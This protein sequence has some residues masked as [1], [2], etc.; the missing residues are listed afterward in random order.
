MR[1]ALFLLPLALSAQ[2]VN[3]SCSPMTADATKRLLSSRV[4]KIVTPWTVTV[5]NETDSAI[6]ITESAV[7]RLMAPLNPYDRKSMSLL[8]DEGA[9]NSGWART[10]RATGDV[11]TLA[12]FLSMSKDIRW[13]ESAPRVIAGVLAM[14]PYIV[15]RIKGAE[16]PVRQN[17]ESIAWSEALALQP[18]ES[19]GGRIFTQYWE[20]P[21]AISFAVDVSK[22]RA[23]KALH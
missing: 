22:K 7:L 11:L 2:T 10:G 12:L 4:S 6:S 19:G 15:G 20:K 13:G 17:F 3:I 23:V 1:L 8:V 21:T 18:G 14:G 9:K 16:P 5:D